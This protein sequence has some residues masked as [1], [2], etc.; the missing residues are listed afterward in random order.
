MRVLVEHQ[1]V[2]TNY[3]PLLLCSS[4]SY[5]TSI[6]GRAARRRSIACR[7]RLGSI[8]FSLTASHCARHVLLRLQLDCSRASLSA[9]VTAATARWRRYM[10]RPRAPSNL[11]RTRGRARAHGYRSAPARARPPQ[12]PRAHA[13][14]TSPPRARAHRSAP[15]RAR[16]L[17]RPHMHAPTAAPPRV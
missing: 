15:T 8:F 4:A 2:H 13:P 5:L 3:L 14:T 7:A 16:P 12:R 9:S 1:D 6:M 17:P 11:R 10:Q